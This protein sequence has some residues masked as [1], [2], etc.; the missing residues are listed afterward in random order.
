MIRFSSLIF[1]NRIIIC[2]WATTTHCNTLQHT[3]TPLYTYLNLPPY[4]IA[5]Y[6]NAPHYTATGP[7]TSTHCNWALQLTVSVPTNSVYDC[8]IPERTTLH[9][10]SALHRT[11]TAP[12]N[13]IYDCDI[14]EH[15][16]LHRNRALQHTA[17]VPGVYSASYSASP[18]FRHDSIY[19]CT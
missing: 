13:F 19:S 17:T 18:Y 8:N 10:N 7:S 16:T 15:T 11:A 14:P 5:T 1:E 2:I 12:T 4:M 6:Q 3:A 9:R